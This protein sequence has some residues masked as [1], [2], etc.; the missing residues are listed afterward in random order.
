[1]REGLEF[2]DRQLIK[3]LTWFCKLL[4]PN[5]LQ[6]LDLQNLDAEED[7]QEEEEEE[8]EGTTG[9][10]F[11]TTNVLDIAELDI[12]VL[13]DVGTEMANF[14]KA[15]CVT[16]DQMVILPPG[17]SQSDLNGRNGSNACTVIAL[18]VAYFF[19]FSKLLENPLITNILTLFIGCIEVGN[20]LHEGA[21]FLTVPEGLTILEHLLI[22]LY[23]ER[24]C[25]IAGLPETMKELLC[26]SN[27]AI[28][29]AEQKTVCVVQ[30]LNG[31]FFLFDS[32]QHDLMGASVVWHDNVENIA[33]SI[34][35]DDEHAMIYACSISVDLS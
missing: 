10:H 25:F 34:V 7:E 16:T 32:H 11:P 6:E 27:V 3:G 15:L 31:N 12:D 20:T 35:L 9:I 24:N 22:S 2:S 17:Y 26:D 21:E 19:P 8:E 28:V 14:D 5:V 18:L 23:K 1:M 33:Q 29:I 13:N 4:S 30:T